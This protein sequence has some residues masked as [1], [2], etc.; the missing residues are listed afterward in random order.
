MQPSEDLKRLPARRWG[1]IRR[2]SLWDAGEYLLAV[3]GTVFSERYQRLYY[4]D[5]QSI[6]VQKGARVGSIGALLI[7]LFVSALCGTIPPLR[8][9]WI[10]PLAWAVWLIYA[11]LARGCRVF[12]YTEVSSVELHAIY[13]SRAA[14]RVL[15][16]ILSKILAA[17]GPLDDAA[18]E[19]PIRQKG[20]AGSNSPA[21]PIMAPGWAL[22]SALVFFIL[23]LGS[24]AFA[25]WYSNA[26]LTPDLLRFAKVMGY[27][28]NTLEVVTG[29]I[30]VTKL[31]HIRIMAAVRILIFGGL[32]L[33]AA[34]SYEFML[35]LMQLAVLKGS[36]S[37]SM[38]K[39]QLRQNLGTG[40][41]AF[42]LLVAVAGLISLLMSWRG[43][44]SNP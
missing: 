8:R 2:A 21:E 32:G 35:I 19:S 6:V 38:T 20:N 14:D 34:R 7:S 23:F 28:I 15:P 4:R 3:S 17:Q 18:R 33:L 37:E 29:V 12:L 44:P 22:Y 11:N 42:S 39:V 26:L 5:I 31:F 27:F 30:A 43:S 40:D 16:Q 1:V 10:L 13:R 9:L 25:Y 24:A 36:L 41:C